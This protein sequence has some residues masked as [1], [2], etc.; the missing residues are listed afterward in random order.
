MRD[1]ILTMTN[2]DTKANKHKISLYLE[3]LRC[4]MI[5]CKTMKYLVCGLM[6]K[7][8]LYTLYE[9]EKQDNNY[10]KH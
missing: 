6:W 4:N 8:P 5:V 7:L 2:T 1:K 3:A 9:I 10:D